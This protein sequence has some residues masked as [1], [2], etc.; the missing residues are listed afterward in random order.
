MVNI[1]SSKTKAHSWA[2]AK[3]LAREHRYKTKIGLPKDYAPFLPPEFESSARS[4]PGTA[5]AVYRD[6]KPKDSFQVREY[7]DR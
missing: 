6:Q 2:E 4:I 7:D 5:N 1:T 3:R